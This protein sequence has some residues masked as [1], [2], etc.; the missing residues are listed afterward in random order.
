[1]GEDQRE[2]KL[3]GQRYRDV[4][5]QKLGGSVFR[6]QHGAFGWKLF[7]FGQGR[8]QDEYWFDKEEFF[9]VIALDNEGFRWKRGNR[10]SEIEP[11]KES[12][13]RET[14]SIWEKEN[15]ERGS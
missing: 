10:L 15:R 1:M 9:E 14:I 11:S 7:W 6:D 13:M 2:W 4:G 8:V 5:D 12:Y 3:L